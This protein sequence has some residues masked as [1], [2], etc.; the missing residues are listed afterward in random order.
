MLKL[1]I[2]FEFLYHNSKSFCDYC[3]RNKIKDRIE[4][5]HIICGLSNVKYKGT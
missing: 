5:C 4:L 3:E 1:S 2:E